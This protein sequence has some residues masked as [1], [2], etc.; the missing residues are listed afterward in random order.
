MFVVV[1]E[2]M[3]SANTR[4]SKTS[5][6]HMTEKMHLSVS[7]VLLKKPY[8]LLLLFELFVGI[9]RTNIFREFL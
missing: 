7:F 8:I 4:S 3:Y 6:L 5:V 9:C 1:D 2:N